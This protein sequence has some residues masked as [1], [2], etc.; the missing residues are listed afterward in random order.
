[1]A[2]PIKV[3]STFPMYLYF[4][5]GRWGKA[6]AFCLVMA[7]LLA[8]VGLSA[9]QRLLAQDLSQIKVDDLTDR[10]ISAIYS[11]I[12]ASGLSESELESLA[13]SNNMPLTELTKLRVRLEKLANTTPANP[14]TKPV[15]KEEGKRT[16]YSTR[17]IAFELDDEQK[18]IFGSSLFNDEQ[19]TFEPSLLMAAPRNYLMGPGDELVIDIWGASKNHYRLE[20]D[21][22]GAVLIENIGP[23]FVS[24]LTIEN[25]R[26]KVRQRLGEIYAGINSSAPNTYAQITLGSLRSIKVTLLGEVR[27]PGTYTLPSLATVFNALYLSGGPSEIGSFRT[28]EVI[29]GGRKVATLD[30]Y[31]FLMGNSISQNI[32]LQ[33]QDIIRIPAFE[34]RIELM[35]EVKRPGIYEVSEDE[36]LEEVVAYAGGFTDQAY[37]HRLKVT[38]ST[39]RE[40]KI[41]DVTQEQWSDFALMN[42]DVINV[43]PVLERFSNRVTIRG[44][45]YR[46]GE[47]ELSEGLTLKSLLEKAEGVRDDAFLNRALIQR[48]EDDRSKT[49]LPIDLGALLKG[50]VAD[51][52]L[53]REDVVLVSSVYELKEDYF[54]SIEGEV[55]TP[56]TYPFMENMT[57]EDLLII[58]GGFSESASESRI[59]IA[60]RVRNPEGNSG[61]DKVAELLEISIDRD[62][63]INGGDKFVL[64]PFD[65]VFVRRFPGYEEQQSVKIT[66]EVLYPGNYT[67]GKKNERIS[68]LVKRA[69]GTTDFAYADGATLNRSYLGSRENIGI[70]L[71]KIMDNPG[72]KEDI[73]LLAG[74]S[75]SIPKELQTV[76][77]NG[78]V[79]FPISVRYDKSLG[80][81]DYIA[82]AGGF[83]YQARKGK[84]FV[85]YANGSV[86]QTGRLLFF[87]RYPRVAPG[88]EIYVPSKPESREVST[89]EVIGWTTGFATLGL[90]IV[91]IIQATP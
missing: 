5:F 86:R 80:F 31:D 72:T 52:P 87:R 77:V 79:L 48:T 36:K 73:F 29:R 71:K 23:V 56:G 7:C 44:A 62:L 67:I 70:D 60:R 20:V 84:V 12:Q 16:D 2:N 3:Q 82:G 4:N 15:A 64:E 47:Y 39:G 49:I 1:M 37:Y 57:L 22:E 13:L 58:S 11:E 32:R 30:V 38:R 66:G 61:N 91:N 18:K 34:T 45:V 46:P 9:Q 65:Q 27:A 6:L 83:G 69:G 51:L 76:R 63:N 8:P 55:Q 26:E 17:S 59:E 85:R 89:Q 28:I 24:G 35:G 33:D 42:G 40:R 41:A 10:E 21:R 54:V 74:D 88:S 78:Q 43:E 90:I 53:Q 25:A 14:Q 68:D 50:G 75:I 81:K 19:L